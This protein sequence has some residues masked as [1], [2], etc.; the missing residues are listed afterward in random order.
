M[1]RRV[2]IRDPDT[3]LLYNVSTRHS[4]LGPESR[5]YLIIPDVACVGEDTSA[6]ALA[7]VLKYKG[8]CRNDGIQFYNYRYIIHVTGPIH[9]I[10]RLLIPAGRGGQSH[11]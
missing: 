6:H 1:S 9:N 5:K 4:G 7:S 10:D 8:I 2:G 11:A 3:K